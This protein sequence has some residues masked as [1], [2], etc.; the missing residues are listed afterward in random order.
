MPLETIVDHVKPAHALRVVMLDACRDNPFVQEAHRAQSE[1]RSIELS[2]E[3]LTA[4]QEIGGGVTPPVK[5][6]DVGTFLAFAAEHGEMALDGDGL[7]SPFAE[8]LVREIT[9]PDLEIRQLFEKIRGDVLASTQQL[10][11]PTVYYKL[12]EDKKYVFVQQ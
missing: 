2:P 11:H 8:A 4:F 1:S 9:Q 7:D 10:Q 12:P 6:E 3:E 5:A